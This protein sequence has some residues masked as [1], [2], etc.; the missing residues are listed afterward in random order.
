MVKEKLAFVV[1]DDLIYQQ[2]MQGHMKNLGYAV[3]SFYNGQSCLDELHQKPDLI[4][5]D[6]QLDEEENGLEVLRKIKEVSPKVPVI[7]LSAQNDLATAVQALKFGS[8]DYIEKNTAT[9]VRLRTTVDRI[10]EW[11][12]AGFFK[13]LTT[14][15]FRF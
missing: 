6:H 13:K 2:F 5:L 3:R 4:I 9:Y 11:Q 12:K 14:T 8:F 15:L 7:Y 1:D 10:H